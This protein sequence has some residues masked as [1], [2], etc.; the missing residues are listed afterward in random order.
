MFGVDELVS[1]MFPKSEE[2]LLLLTELSSS[3]SGR[4]EE[5]AIRLSD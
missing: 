1:G 4:R 2:I 5:L 3:E